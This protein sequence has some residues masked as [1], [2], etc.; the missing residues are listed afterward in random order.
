MTGLERSINKKSSIEGNEK[1]R[2]DGTRKEVETDV[3]MTHV[4]C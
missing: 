4:P 1:K 2:R 3:L